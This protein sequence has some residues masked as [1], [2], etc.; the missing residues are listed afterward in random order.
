MPL[1]ICSSQH[2]QISFESSVDAQLCCSTCCRSH[3]AP[4]NFTLSM[5]LAFLS[6]ACHVR[7]DCAAVPTPSSLSGK[8][9]KAEKSPYAPSATKASSAS[10]PAAVCRPEDLAKAEAAAVELLPTRF[11]V[12]VTAADVRKHTF[13]TSDH[14]RPAVMCVAGQATYRLCCCR[15][16]TF[17][18]LQVTT[19]LIQYLL[20]QVNDGHLLPKKWLHNK[21]VR[22]FQNY[23][24]KVQKDDTAEGD[25]TVALSWY[26]VDT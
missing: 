11:A 19:G 7:Q 3:F 21:L 8:K 16:S 24:T 22:K 10:S 4:L 6:P 9:R 17:L 14:Q 26:L 5:F 13:T 15:T 20:A 23:K 2:Y 18:V 25:L 1:Y 12:M